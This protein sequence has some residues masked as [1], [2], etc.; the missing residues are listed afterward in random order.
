MIRDKAEYG[1]FQTPLELTRK[2]CR[3]LKTQ[4]VLPEV[5]VEPTFGQGHFI[6]AALEIFP[7]I[8]HV[9]GVEIYGPYVDETKEQIE[10]FFSERKKKNKPTIDL[11]QDDVFFFPFA[12]IARKH[13]KDKV[14]I[15]GNPPWVTNA[16]LSLKESANVP[17]KTNFKAVSGIEAIT[18]KGNF[19]IGESVTL[20]ML[21][22]FSRSN[23][24]FAFLVK[25]IVI[26]NIVYSQR[27]RQFPIGK[28]QQIAIDAKKEFNVSVDASVFY[29][30]L[31]HKPE[32]LCVVAE[33]LE[34]ENVHTLGWVSDKFVADVEQYKLAQ[35]LD[36]VS[37]I[38]WRQGIKHDCSSVMELTKQGTVY[39]NSLKES[40]VLEDDLVYPL[41]KSSDLKEPVIHET[42]KQVIVPQ[43]L[44]GQST[45]YIKTDYPR[46]F[47][48]LLKHREA[49]ERRKSSIYNNKPPFSIFGVGYYSF[50]PYKVAISGLYKQTEF[51][52][53]MPIDCKPVM[54]D[55]TCYFLGFDSL[56]EAVCCLYLLNH[57]QMQE[58]L[59][60]LIF[61]ESKRVIT[62]DILMRLDY[63]RLIEKTSLDEL[64]N[65]CSTYK[66]PCEKKR[67]RENWDKYHLYYHTTRKRLLFD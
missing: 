30:K 38:V 13:D 56:P 45:S 51:S 9:Y 32:S 28:L 46:T 7:T 49:F 16:A 20:T 47:S 43:Q 18:G 25:S 29:A 17:Q 48:Y 40:V 64:A 31:G 23:G 61:W 60:S 12:E 44:V 39:E 8:E 65:Y 55:D 4:G 24:H 5:L 2:L 63:T 54:L 22:A 26:R 50:Q 41:L 52:L 67:L 33:S 42:R 57:P 14:L 21:N 66:I 1:D 37:P 15:L 10:R 11:H 27:T 34:S 35:E 62:K 3:R 59:C 58:L 36:G 53:V 19:D 6:L